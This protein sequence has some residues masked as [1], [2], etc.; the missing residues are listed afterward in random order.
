VGIFAKTEP[1]VGSRRSRVN[2]KAALRSC[3]ES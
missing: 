2:S 3:H 1:L